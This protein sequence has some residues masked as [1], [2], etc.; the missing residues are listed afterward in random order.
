M[1]TPTLEKT[2]SHWLLRP[3]VALPL[4][5][6]FLVIVALLTPENVTGR[7]GDARLTTYGTGP[8]NAAGLYEVARRLGWRVER[9]R[10]PLPA[11]DDTLAIQAELNPSN[12]LSTIEAH[13]LLDGVR[14]G[15]ALL[16]VFEGGGPLADSLHVAVGDGYP[17]RPRLGPVDSASAARCPANASPGLPLWFGGAPLLESVRWLRP[18]PADTVVF[19]VVVPPSGPRAARRLP[20]AV[21]FPYGRGRV[22]VI[23]DPDLLRNDVIRVCDWNA[24]V[25]AVR[26][27]EYLSLTTAAPRTRLVFDEYHQG[28]GLHPGTMRAITAYLGHTPSGHVLAQLA[29][30][31]IVLLFAL[32]PRALPPREDV[33]VQRRS[34]LEHVDALAR[35]YAQVGATRTAVLRLLHGARRRLRRVGRD[36]VGRPDAEFLA[37]VERRTPALA[38]EVALVRHA[39]ESPASHHELESAGAALRRIESSLTTITS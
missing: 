26:M 28:Y 29:V 3:A 11:P 6:V 19:A 32:G 37:D 17:Y 22:V 8:L 25:V 36:L 14:R 33:R 20:A 10:T 31:G 27:L 23:P 13:A 18:P 9:R 1:T 34:P 39:L 35:A 5:V 38:A 24:D 15:G 7:V 2:A 16:Y 21:G 30:A 12:G 4:V